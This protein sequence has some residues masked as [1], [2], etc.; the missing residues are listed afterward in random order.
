MLD[1]NDLDKDYIDEMK[2]G[3]TKFQQKKMDRFWTKLTEATG[4]EPNKVVCV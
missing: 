4:S 1:L 2:K 3:L